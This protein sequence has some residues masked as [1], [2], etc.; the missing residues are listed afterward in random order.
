[1]ET[2][3]Y[4]QARRCGDV[5]VSLHPAGHILGSAQVR[6]EYRGETWVVTGDY[7]RQT[8]NTCEPFETLLCHTL[9]TESTFGLPVYRWPPQER[10]WHE[11]NTWWQ[12][13][14]SDGYASVLFAYAL[15]K[16]QR[17]AAHVDA[18]LGPIFVHGAVARLH[19][20]YQ[21]SGVSLPAC[22]SVLD[23]R[24]K[25]DFRRA[26]VIAPPSAAGTPWVRRFG[27]SRMAVASGWMMI[28]GTRRRRGVD[29]G[30]VLSDHVDWPDLLTTISESGAENVWVTHGYSDI[31]ARYLGDLGLN[32]RAIPA[33]YGDGRW[34]E[35]VA[36]D[37]AQ[38]DD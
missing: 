17:I 30:F 13:N 2:L 8:D 34:D 38:S 28:R 3:P 36:Q 14:Q 26:L 21:A 37:V 33:R 11:I 6:V 35:G 9:V 5:R 4:G 31:V 24:E 15:G 22:Q 1:L 10:V 25:V 12:Q 18:T 19:R 7:K 16:A 29:R 20:A 23:A 32:A 27:E